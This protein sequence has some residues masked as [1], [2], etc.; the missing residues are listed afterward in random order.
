TVDTD[1]MLASLRLKM[2]HKLAMLV[3]VLVL[4]LAY[5][6]YRYSAELWSRIDEHALAQD[7][8]RYS[9]ELNEVGRELADH[10]SY[11]ATLLAGEANTAFFDKQ[12]K[13]DSARLDS[14][15]ATQEAAEQ[16]YGK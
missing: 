10:A 9:Q 12:I 14:S 6:S 11:T 15:I 5:V 3:V 2:A 16:K 8:L 4:P 7:G 1:A 13:D